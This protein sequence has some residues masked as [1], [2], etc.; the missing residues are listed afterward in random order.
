MKRYACLV[1]LCL[2]T[3]ARAQTPAPVAPPPVPAAPPAAPEQPVVTDDGTLHPTHADRATCLLLDTTPGALADPA[4][5]TDQ[6]AIPIAWSDFAV[7]GTYVS[8]DTKDTLHALFEPTF[9]EHR[10]NFT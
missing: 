5:T 8:G 4:P 2:A 10:T 7:E 3:H 1:L 9:N 6:L